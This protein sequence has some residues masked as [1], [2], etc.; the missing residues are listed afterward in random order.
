LYPYIARLKLRSPA[1]TNLRPS[2]LPSPPTRRYS[3]TVHYRN[4]PAAAL[5]ALEAAISDVAA[6]CAG[7]LVV[8][9]GKKVR[10][11]R[12]D[13]PWNKGAAVAWIIKA[14]GFDDAF[15][16]YVGDDTTDEDAF[17]LFAGPAAA[18]APAARG[19]GVLVSDDAAQ[20]TAA[21][22]RLGSVDEVHDFLTKIVA[23]VR[24][25]DAADDSR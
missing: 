18:A 11:F 8:T 19:V 13:L 3:I 9:S 12:P 16:I 4:C 24:D 2:T 1:S 25:R 6:E 7:R 17:R 5:P 21:T 10:E 14:N 23:F 15:T 22:L 20:P